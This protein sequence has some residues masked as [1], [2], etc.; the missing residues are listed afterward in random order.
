M[1][2]TLQGAG[3]FTVVVVDVRNGVE[4]R[5]CCGLQRVSCDHEK[6]P[7]AL[8]TGITAIVGR[9]KVTRLSATK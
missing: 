1:Q 5:E 6:P 3:L 4:L 8:N 7:G 9:T 2:A